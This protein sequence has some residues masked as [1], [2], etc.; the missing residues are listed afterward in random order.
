M[1]VLVLILASLFLFSASSA[2]IGPSPEAPKITIRFEEQ[3]ATYFDIT[4][5]TYHCSEAE[6]GR[7]SPV[8][9]REIN[10]SCIAGL[11][12]NDMW[13][14]K[15]NPCFH[16]SGHFSYEYN[17]LRIMTEVED[18]SDKRTYDYTV[19]VESG[20][21]TSKYA[22]PEEPFGTCGPTFMLAGM[23]GIAFVLGRRDG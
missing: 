11:C 12:K 3:G 14:Y 19:D 20:Q 8:D 16:S 22:F 6:T 17:G 10:M 21:F 5:L 2:D 13:F 1:R 15:L 18:F 9:D 4:N 23:L 7:S